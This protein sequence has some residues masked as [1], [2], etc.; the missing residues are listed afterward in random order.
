M[1][2]FHSAGGLEGVLRELSPALAT[3]CGDV[4]GGPLAERLARPLADPIDRKVIRAADN[5]ISPNGGLIA[6][7]GSLAPGGAILKR[8]AATPEL[9]EH[10][11]SIRNP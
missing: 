6:V 11:G 7:R 3:E 10:E 1:E 9:T 2:D 4:T 5:P 8:A